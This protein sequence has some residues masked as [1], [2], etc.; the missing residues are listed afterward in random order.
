MTSARTRG[1]L[2]AVAGAILLL[3]AGRWAAGIL[4]ERWW[5]AGVAPGAVAFLARWELLRTGLE[6]G[7]ILVASAWCVGHLLLVVRSIRAVQVPRRVG[8][9]EIREALPP[10]SLRGGAVVL[11]LL[12]GLLI[13]RGGAEGAG[14]VMLA[15]RGVRFGIMD[16]ALGLDAGVYI[17]Q[18]PFW[19]RLLHSA[20]LLTWT[21]V[22]LA[23]AA[24]FAVGGIRVARGGIAM[25]EQARAQVGWLLAGAL[26]LGAIREGLAPVTTIGAGD[27]WAIPVIPPMVH[28]VVAGAWVVSALFL[29][30]WTTR[31]LPANL[32]V[33][34][35]LW[36]TAG[37]I[38][39]VI[40]PGRDISPSLP[41]EPLRA[42]AA[43]NS[44]S[45]ALVER[46]GPAEQEL[47][48]PPTGSL[49]GREELW[50]GL[51]G[52][53]GRMLALAP[54]R[55]PH[56][57]GEVPVWL[58]VRQDS[59]GVALIAVADDRLAPGGGTVSFRQDDAA[60]YPGVVSWARLTGMD[61]RPE[62]PDTVASGGEDGILLGG[63]L[64]RLLVSWGAQMA[65]PLDRGA[66][67]ERLARYRDPTDRA[68]RLFPAL[69]WGGATP[70]VDTAGFGWLVDGW[71]T[72][73]WGAF[74]SPIEWWPGAPRYARPEVIAWIDA[75]SGRTRFFLRGD[76]DAVGQAW[77]RLAGGLIE[78]W[79]NAPPLVRA[80]PM[81]RNWVAVL[82]RALSRPPF[83]APEL[84]PLEGGDAFPNHAWSGA[85]AAWQAPLTRG[86]RVARL[87]TG[88]QEGGVARMT[89]V[90]WS[91]SLHAPF[92]PARYGGRWERFA[93]YERL[94]D[95]VT[96]A[97]GRLASSGV[98][99]EVGP[100][101]TTAIQVVYLVRPG[102]G[103][104]LGWV[105]L[106]GAGRLGAART[107]A[108]AWANLLGESAPLVP[109]P[110]VPDRIVEARRWA[111][112]ADSA[113]RA[114]DLAAFGR[115]FE[116]LKQ[117]LGTP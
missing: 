68:T 28:W 16:P 22:A 7:G 72:S 63:P 39:R 8:D 30:R 112:R 2:A 14:E 102:G 25:T 61:L 117:V 26:L 107:P 54:A 13:G 34:I 57:G 79:A 82:A 6:L 96:A 43:V 108:A 35:G 73:R 45:G 4:V 5:A 76:A 59:A 88:S 83:V 24:H 17:A 81:P 100:A 41:G 47:Q 36:A 89:L 10:E 23:V 1:L 93:S 80:A 105:N 67:A 84:P 15:W 86:G 46:A 29:A 65:G 27:P 94:G 114:G 74:S 20:A 99:Y 48:R 116:A 53:E 91:D 18:M 42:I 55:I 64:Q 9:L 32:L 106:A 62:A 19:D 85:E 50:A 11:G 38:S 44:G 98:R 71:A 95:S 111:A 70:V 31:P 66:G 109:D 33:A 77:A 90:T 75:R 115:A 56:A 97:G 12:L 52:T 104:S 58:G 101:G 69:W 37:I 110:D 51:Q 87:L 78:P 92:A 21:S 113:L 60:D 49:W 40:L 3:F 103:I